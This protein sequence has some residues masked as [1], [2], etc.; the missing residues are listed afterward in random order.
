M[1]MQR[2]FQWLDD[3]WGNNWETFPLALWLF[4]DK[5]L[6]YQHDLYPDTMTG[7][8]EMLTWNAAWGYMLSFDWRP[9]VLG[10]PWPKIVAAFQ[11]AL[12]PRFA[13][14]ALTGFDVPRPGI[15]HTEFGS[16]SVVANTTSSTYEVDGLRIAPGGFLARDGGLVAGAFTGSFAGRALSPGT[17]YLIIENGKTTF[18]ATG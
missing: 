10:G 13:G 9:D 14:K 7:D 12:G 3:R 18:Q 2:E 17:H 15:T 16:Y 4:H 6:I 11:S 1:M 5:V 8:A